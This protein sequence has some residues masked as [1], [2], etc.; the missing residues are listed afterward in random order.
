MRALGDGCKYRWSLAYPKLTSGC[1]AKFLTDHRLVP[2][3][4]RGCWGPLLS[5]LHTDLSP[6]SF[7]TLQ[8]PTVC[9]MQLFLLTPPWAPH[10]GC[11]VFLIHITGLISHLSWSCAQLE[12]VGGRL[13]HSLSV[14][15]GDFLCLK[16]GSLRWPGPR[17]P[18]CPSLAGC[19]DVT[20]D[21]SRMWLWD[22]GMGKSWL[23]LLLAVPSSG[24]APTPN[25]HVNIL[26][27]WLYL[28]IGCLKR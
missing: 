23:C 27:M 11:P 28:E 1:A 26:R 13:L 18:A 3:H 16:S 22:R 21:Q 7:P 5:S 25:S 9:Y 6:S 8:L 20:V 12:P 15:W 2:V 14:P 10:P 24:V 4:G 17:T 19:A